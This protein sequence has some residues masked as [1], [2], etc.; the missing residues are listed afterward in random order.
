[1]MVPE[2]TVISVIGL[3]YVGLPSA[4]LFASAGYRVVGVDVDERIVGAV[5]AGRCPFVEPGLTGLVSAAVDAGLLTATSAPV[6]AD[7]F[8]IAVPTPVQPGRGADLSYVEAATDSIAPLLRGGDLV[9]IE[10]TCPPGT[11]RAMAER[12]VAQRPDLSWQG[13][14]AGVVHF[15]HCP[16]R[17]LPGRAMVELVEN[18]RIIGGLTDE[19][20]TRA[21]SLY[22]SV[23]RGELRTT[24]AETAE[25]A[26]LTEN[27]F[28][29]VNIAFA[30]E[31][32]LVCARLGVDVWSLIELANLHPRVNILQPGPGVG[33]HCIAVDPW[34]IVAA[35]PQESR[36]I[37]TAR[38]V[39]DGKPEWVLEAIAQAVEA[40]GA[41]HVACLGLSFKADIDDT[42][43]SPAMH[44]TAEL[45]AR[46]P[47][48]AIH[49]V[50][51]HLETLPAEL[52][53]PNLRH[54]RLDTALD[55]A[56][57]VVLLVDHT[58]F[59]AV[60]PRT[61]QGKRVIDTRG[62]WRQR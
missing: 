26:K 43:E 31:L 52:G 32:S 14:G 58:Q 40:S 25:L 9:V 33:G 7:V 35:A 20:A 12:V 10:S 61:L 19:A 30:N 47:D 37:R 56:E 28:R 51:P 59:R 49:V 24:T 62:V 41:Q 54:S 42:R 53:A 15:A 45:A 22:S 50:E 48:L 27:A 23:C 11:A 21:R 17:V 55:E 44:I 2:E 29:D 8:L 1:M 3:G 39:N 38:E 5:N 34:F 46:Y 57:V 36:L 18:S 16:E 60:D 4:A 13:D 6:E